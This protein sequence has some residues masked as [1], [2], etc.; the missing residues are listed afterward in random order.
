MIHLIGH[1]DI[2]PRSPNTKGLL[3]PVYGPQ[4]DV[5]GHKQPYSGDPASLVHYPNAPLNPSRG[6]ITTQ[7]M[8]GRDGWGLLI[9]PSPRESILM[10]QRCVER[11]SDL[12][13]YMKTHPA[14][15]SP[16]KTI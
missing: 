9:Y 13:L 6:G 3:L 1:F 4:C 8:V 16:R 12:V 5:C 7:W 2:S 10:C 14:S 11:V 15:S